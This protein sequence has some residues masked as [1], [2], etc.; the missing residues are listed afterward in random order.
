[1]SN[2]TG[3]ESHLLE[4]Q[5]IR[6]KAEE[7]LK[8]A[9]TARQKA[10]SEAL[11]AS[12]AKGACES[13]STTI[14][15]LKG[16]VEADVN[17]ILSNKQKSDELLAAVNA[18][19]ATIDAEMKTISDRRKEVDQASLEIV[20]AAQSG[21]A[22]SKDID[23]SKATSEAALNSIN[24]MLKSATHAR[25]RA[26]TAQKEAESFSTKA[27][28]LAVSVTE[29]HG[30]STQHSSEI[31]T[32]L[33][34]AQANQANLAKV[35]DHL[36]KSDEIAGGYEARVEKLIDELETLNKRVESL[37]PGATSAGLA[38]SFNQQKARFVAPQKR[39]LNMFVWCMVGLIIIAL[40]SFIAAVFGNF[41]TAYFGKDIFGQS[42][43]STW[44]S[45]FRNLAMRLPIVIPLV[46][47]A[48]YAGRNYMLSLRLEEDYAYKE[49]ISTAFEGYK[50]E[51]KEIVAVDTTSPAPL[52]KLCL[53]V[54][55]AIAE[56]PGRIYEG[57]H[58]DITL[59]NE[60][61]EKGEDFRKKTISSS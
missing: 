32:L 5:E 44:D 18:G 8:A 49:A 23:N 46:W 15:S 39:W 12:N 56:R 24:E 17:S 41:I 61:M 58:Q 57:K 3:T 52:T 6:K 31:Q 19:K 1:M 36:K 4:I 51:M 20:T 13:H 38:S 28:E 35:L 55:T 34:E 33:A 14:A 22:H 16:S 25:T 59:I 42:M 37:L 2:E 11:Y 7:Q 53:N 10:D 43:N 26:E 60:I 29:S 54:L 21:T 30:A 50:R 45:T 40:P 27:S 48:I 9:E 47:L